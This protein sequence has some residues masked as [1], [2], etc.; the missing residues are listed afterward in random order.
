MAWMVLFF[1]LSTGLRTMR[2]VRRDDRRDKNCQMGDIVNICKWSGWYCNIEQKGWSRLYF[3]KLFVLLL[4][5]KILVHEKF[6]DGFSSSIFP[7]ILRRPFVFPYGIAMLASTT[8]ILIKLLVWSFAVRFSSVIFHQIHIGKN[9]ILKVFN[10]QVEH[11]QFWLRFLTSDL[12]FGFRRWSVLGAFLK[13]QPT[14]Q[15]QNRSIES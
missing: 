14:W 6:F 1:R 11:T 3:R 5:P 7:V 15:W 8:W 4:R 10:F 12:S 2:S 13:T 9:N